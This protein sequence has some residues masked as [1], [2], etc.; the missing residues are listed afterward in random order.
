MSSDNSSGDVNEI[1][2]PTT[3]VVPSKSFESP[4]AEYSFMVV[5]THSYSPESSEFFFY[6]SACDL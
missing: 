1:V 5:P 2:E 6:D 4:C 3:F